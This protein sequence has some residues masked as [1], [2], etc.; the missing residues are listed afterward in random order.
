MDVDHLVYGAPDLLTGIRAVEKLLGVRPAP[1]GKH[2]G[3]GTHNALASLG[4]DA[5]LEVIASD[6]EQ[7]LPD[8]LTTLS[9]GVRGPRPLPYGLAT[10]AEPR[11]LTWAV[12]AEDIESQ[13]QQARA[14]GLDLGA[15]VRM[16]RERPDGSRLEWSL[17]R[18]ALSAG[19]GLVPF[20][21]AWDPGPHPSETSPTGAQLLALHAEHPEP[22]R[23]MRMLDILG[24]TLPMRQGPRP[25]LVAIVEGVRGT[26]ELR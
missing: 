25:A 9:H 16:S 17:T 4:G 26:V 14:A 15:V 3:V 22:E 7:P 11:L 12:K 19:D 23:I 21:I 8:A 1:G 13:A 2:V 6:P 10:L 20:L 5:Y 18:S 24:I